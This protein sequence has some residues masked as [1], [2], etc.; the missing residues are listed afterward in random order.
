MN[1]RLFLPFLRSGT[2][3]FFRTGPRLKI[4]L[5]CGLGLAICLALFLL[6]HRSVSY[7]QSQSELGIILSMKIFQMAWITIFAML[8][9]SSMIA[10]VS[11]LYLSRD[12][13]IVVAAPI[14]L[15]ELFRMRLFTTFFS[16]SWMM[17]IFSL[18]V[19]IAFGVVFDAGPLY[20]PLLVCVI[21]A[22]ALT[23]CG[24]AVLFVIVLVYLF[25]ARR[26]KDIIVYLTVCF[27][28]FLYLIFR[29]MRPEDLV[30]PEK[31]G[32]FIEYMS[33]ISNP[34][35]FWL[36]ASWTSDLL[37]SYL[38]DRRV[39]ML[40]VGLIM[41]T[42]AILVMFGELLMERLFIPGFSKS[43]ESF[44]G[45][46]RFREPGRTRSR[47]LW[48]FR[49]ERIGF[50]RDSKEWSQF[51]MIGALVVVYLY[52]FKVL[53]LERT[54]GT[55]YVANLISFGNIGLSGFLSAALAARFVYPSIGGEGGAF[56]LIKTAPISEARF[57]FSKYLFYLIPFT[58][59][60]IVLVTVS[61]RFLQVDGP[62]WWISLFCAI[63]ICWTV[64]AMAL[65]FGA[66]FA[67][68][69]AEHKDASMGPGA[70]LYFFCAIVY[71]LAVL[72]TGFA[73]AHRLVRSWFR[74]GGLPLS[75]ALMIFAW[76]AMVIGLSASIA[77]LIGRRGIAALKAK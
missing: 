1:T 36:P 10:S 60:S 61:N 12:N 39:D 18:P 8:I 30:N 58:L 15:P 62:M 7:F 52:N 3:R 57:F 44:G 59:L 23:A 45:T 56:Y 11:Q 70:I 21:P 73:P 51:F 42:P 38:L 77:V 63:S 65:G 5:L 27:G 69:H 67:D 75:D 28:I 71:M 64:V 55:A 33:A 41:L 35:G 40:L 17:L 46:H 47:L 74:H 53:P 31:Y 25:P 14:R 48:I 50:L 76:G 54:F 68:Y 6:T 9:F 32:Q 29:L 66:I 43:Q 2:N 19:F 13:E 72:V 49:K 34:A 24:L 20:I 4:T 16:T 26:T 22:T 37:S